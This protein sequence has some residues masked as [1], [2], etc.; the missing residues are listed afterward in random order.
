S[1]SEP[2]APPTKSALETD[3]SGWID[4]LADGDL[5]DWKRVG[6]KLSKRDPWRFEPKE[7]T[8]VCEGSVRSG[9]EEFHEKLLFS[10][11]FGDGIFHLEWRFRKS[12]RQDYNS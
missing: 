12:E 2:V 9:E 5:K 8:L 7:E 6:S 3:S 4:L 10:K 1:A 11:E